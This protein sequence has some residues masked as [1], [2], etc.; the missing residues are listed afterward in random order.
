M[1]T[2]IGGNFYPDAVFKRL[3]SEI[4]APRPCGY[5]DTH[6][7]IF[8]QHA[9]RAISEKNDGTNVAFFHVINFKDFKGGLVYRIPCKGDFN[10]HDVRGF[11]KPIRMLLEPE[12]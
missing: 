2:A 1:V 7:I 12:Y 10:E 6:G 9:H 11:K 5:G 4:C 3:F 8:R